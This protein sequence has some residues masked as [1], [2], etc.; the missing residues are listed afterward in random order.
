MALA[1]QF[2]QCLEDGDLDGLRGI[3]AEAAPHLP[4]GM[5]DAQ[6]EIVM[7]R[8][9][10]EAASITLRARAYSHRWLCERNLPSG[11][12]DDLKPKA[13]R[14]YPRLV[15]AVGISVKAR[16][17]DFRP[18]A[19]MIQTAMSDAV[20]EAYAD[21]RGADIPFVR[22]RMREAR[23]RTLNKLFG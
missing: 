10:T 12:P 8:A 19:L 17:P 3:W 1:D 11:L 22:K 7:H 14:M 9:R 23:A 18:A 5:S 20:E 2:R 16:S 13:E 4:Q 6:A 15:D 21:G